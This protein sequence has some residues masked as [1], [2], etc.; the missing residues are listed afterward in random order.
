MSDRVQ[1]TASRLKKLLDATS[2]ETQFPVAMHLPSFGHEDQRLSVRIKVHNKWEAFNL[3]LYILLQNHRDA[4]RVLQT[5]GVKLPPERRWKVIDFV[6]IR[7]NFQ[8]L[9][10]GLVLTPVHEA[11]QTGSIALGKDVVLDVPLVNGGRLVI[12]VSV[13]QPTTLDCNVAINAHAV[14]TRPAFNIMRSTLSKCTVGSHTV[15]ITYH[16]PDGSTAVR[17]LPLIPKRGAQCDTP[18]QLVENDR[19]TA[20][21][22]FERQHG[23]ASQP[24]PTV[25]P[26]AAAAASQPGPIVPPPSAAAKESEMLMAD[27]TA[28]FPHSPLAVMFDD[29]EDEVMEDD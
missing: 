22:R 12:T 9:F 3:S 2:E 11:S 21:R 16:A 24:G 20:Q 5:T 8:L 7:Q 26:P 29:G 28:D 10:D 4:R 23:N 1:D 6:I 15:M 27:E 18:D 17:L 13:L 25:P 19:L 14:S